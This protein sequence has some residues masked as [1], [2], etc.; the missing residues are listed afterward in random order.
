MTSLFFKLNF[1][2]HCYF[3]FVLVRVFIYVIYFI[4]IKKNSLKIGKYKSKLIADSKFIN[5]N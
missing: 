5:R 3:N 1:K 4:K 2:F